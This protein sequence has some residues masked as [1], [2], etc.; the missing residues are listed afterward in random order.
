MK[1]YTIT[2]LC[3]FLVYMSVHTQPKISVNAPELYL[4]T[5]YSGETIKGTITIKNIGTDTLTIYD[6]RPTCGCTTVKQPKKFLLPRESDNIEVEFHSSGYRGN[7]TK[8]V[9]ITSNDPSS[10]YVTVKLVI[11]VIEILTPQ[12]L[13]PWFGEIALNDTSTRV[14]TYTNSSRTSLTI[15]NIV[16]S[17]KTV[18]VRWEKKTLRPNDTYSFQVTVQATTPGFRNEYIWI[19]TDHPKQKRYE[20]RISFIGKQ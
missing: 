7:V 17:S 9:N 20:V 4:G 8:Y 14:L 10:S 11:D 18:Q 6:I 19:E 5:I 2:I 1:N 15:T 13:T 12:T 16:T 3:T